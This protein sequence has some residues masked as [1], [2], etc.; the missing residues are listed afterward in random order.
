MELWV[1]YY[2]KICCLICRIVLKFT[3]ILANSSGKHLKNPLNLQL[4][5]LI[6]LICALSNNDKVSCPTYPPK[7]GRQKCKHLDK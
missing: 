4:Q 6:D 7:T 3:K 5:D 2:S 1:A